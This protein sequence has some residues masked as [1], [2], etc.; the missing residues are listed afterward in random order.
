MRPE[1]PSE[2][3]QTL[4]ARPKRSNLRQRPGDD[5]NSFSNLVSQNTFESMATTSG[6]LNIMVPS[7]RAPYDT[8]NNPKATLSNADGNVAAIN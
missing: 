6:R 4:L 1:S 2:S 5:A 3:E 7:S 8:L